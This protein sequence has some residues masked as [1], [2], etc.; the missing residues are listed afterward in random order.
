LRRAGLRVDVGL[1]EAEARRLNEDFAAW[2]LRRR[3]FVTL[4][5]AMTLDGRIAERLGGR[6]AITGDASLAAVQKIRHASDAVLT[7]IGTVLADDPLLTD[8]SGLPRRRPLLRIVI[9][10][11]LRIPLKSRLVRSARG[12][13]LVFTTRSTNSAKARALVKAGAEL[14]RVRLQ[15]GRPDLK[16]VLHELG[17]CEI[18][19]VLLEAGPGL[20]G[21]ALEAGI[22]DKMVLFYAPRLIGSG[23][24]PMVN[25]PAGW[26]RRGRRLCIEKVDR[27]GEDFAVEG[28]F[29]DVYGDHR[30]RRKN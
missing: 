1:R 8:R 30:A 17:R 27:Y 14:K 9:D 15:S 11:R 6:T 16:E 25:L 18:L 12:D 23:G 20:N 24:V 13:L 10:S 5:S 21:A 2:I 29:H 22:V 26:L 7:G 4:K 3:P 19:S 28:Y